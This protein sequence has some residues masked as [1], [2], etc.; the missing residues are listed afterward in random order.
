MSL[1][2]CK[3][4]AVF[5]LETTNV[6]I[7]TARIISVGI[8][9]IGTDGSITSGDEMLFNPGV[10]IPPESTKV[11]GITDEMVKNCPAF[12]DRAG[13]ILDKLRGCDLAG[14]NIEKFDLPILRREF[15]RA[16]MDDV[17][18]DA[19]VIDALVI[20]RKNV[21]HDL[22][23][24][25]GYYLHRSHENAH[26]ALADARATAEVLVAQIKKHDLPRDAEG[27]DAYCHERPPSFVDQDG[28]IVW[29][30]DEAVFNFGK[31]K[32]TTLK[33]S[34][35]SQPDYLQWMLAADFTDEV[36]EIVRAILSGVF[37][38]KK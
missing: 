16:G 15:A 3:P 32:G 30:G 22:S 9:V 21:R 25:V 38:Q 2:L 20:Y 19:R 29:K 7:E 28:I 4:I 34:V 8:A 26:T 27:L 37:P 18:K 10:A 11:N 36:K 14:Y 12:S 6:D 17:L 1:N 24:A 23:S 13:D 5:D 33:D 31:L 35:K